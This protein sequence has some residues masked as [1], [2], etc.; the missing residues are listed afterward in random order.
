VAAPKGHRPENGDTGT[1]AS[2]VALTLTYHAQ[3][4]E[5]V[6]KAREVLGLYHKRPGRKAVECD[7]NWGRGAFDTAT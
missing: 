2:A 7:G 3:T 6:G 1:L 5:V 4:A